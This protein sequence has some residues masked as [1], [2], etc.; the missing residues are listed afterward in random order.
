M[1]SQTYSPIS[2]LADSAKKSQKDSLPDRVFMTVPCCLE[3]LPRDQ[4]LVHVEETLRLL[5]AVTG[6]ERYWKAVE[7]L[8]QE[9]KEKGEIKM[10]EILDKYINQGIE[11]GRKQGM[12]EGMEKGMEKGMKRGVK[13]GIRKGFK[14]GINKGEDLMGSLIACLLRDKRDQ[15]IAIAVSDQKARRALYREYNIKA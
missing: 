2:F 6:D 14:Q 7:P 3:N 13:R 9:K 5:Q 1:E 8:L 12:E 11:L 15:D 10:C 4:N